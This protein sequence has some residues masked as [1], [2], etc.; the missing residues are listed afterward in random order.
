VTK[1]WGE[2]TRET[3]FSRNTPLERA[4]N[5]G[6]KIVAKSA[7]KHFLYSHEYRVQKMGGKKARNNFSRITRMVRT[8]NVAKKIVAKNCEKTF[9][10]CTRIS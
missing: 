2:K 3:I 1:K 10:I 7:K 5:V 8:K 6:K 9:F 4:K